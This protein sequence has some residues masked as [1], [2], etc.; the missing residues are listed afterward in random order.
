M[1]YGPAVFFAKLSLFLLYLRIFSPDRWTRVMIYLGA[2]ACFVCYMATAVTMTA[3]CVPR[4]GESWFIALLSSRCH[5]AIT[6]TYVQGIFNIVSDFYLLLLPIPVVWKLQL[7]LRKK[8]GI[9]AIFMTGLLSVPF[10]LMRTSRL[11]LIRD[12][13]HAL[14]ASWG[15]I[16]ELYLLVIAIGHCMKSRCAVLC[17]YCA[18]RNFFMYL[19]G[20]G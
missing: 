8:I 4:H 2:T 18:N 15:C 10:Y 20:P 16:I 1:V 13:G 5:K 11:A 14:L 3:L 9:S 6:M 12:V 17:E 7:T 19:T